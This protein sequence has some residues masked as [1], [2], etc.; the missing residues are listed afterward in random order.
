[1]TPPRPDDEAIA[2]RLRR[3]AGAPDRA[4]WGDVVERATSTARSSQGGRR[5]PRALRPALAV[6]AVAGLAGIVG[7]L[8]VL[9]PKDSP[10]ARTAWTYQTHVP[11][12]EASIPPTIR[13][14]LAKLGPTTLPEAVVPLLSGATFS[15]AV[16]AFRGIGPD[17]RYATFVLDVDRNLQTRHISDCLAD[18]AVV[19]RDPP[20][21]P[22]RIVVPDVSGLTPDEAGSLLQ[23]AGLAVRRLE[24]PAPGRA[25]G[26]A[27]TVIPPIGTSLYVGTAV[28]VPSV[29]RLGASPDA[30]SSPVQL[31]DVGG[32]TR[33]RWI[34]GTSSPDVAGIATAWPDAITVDGRVMN[35]MFLLPLLPRDCRNVGPP[36]S[37]ILTY[38]GG[39][40]IDRLS[41]KNELFVKLAD[42]WALDPE[43]QCGISVAPPTYSVFDRPITA[44]DVLPPGIAEKPEESFPL[45]ID[46]STV[47][48]AR[49]T[50]PAGRYG[51]LTLI[52]VQPAGRRGICMYIRGE[53]VGSGGTCRTPSRPTEGEFVA[54][55]RH[56]A[57]DDPLVVAGV[58]PD[59]FTEVRAGS[60]TSTVDGNVWVLV[61][62]ANDPVPPQVTAVRADGTSTP[63]TI[64]TS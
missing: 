12:D 37:L 1:M 52:V 6:A 7:V 26:I 58:L 44:Q 59:G 11:L 30:P 53:T 56:S 60:R 32:D 62:A 51:R 40:K 10:P 57:A 34:M 9:A 36:K 24:P 54:T 49:T 14:A 61:Y 35:G 18:G 42:T 64:P 15:G 25:V 13:A 33:G 4:D 50:K 27:D 43:P 38:A 23:Q 48:V 22:R 17:G 28:D 55:M 2:A 20:S 16:F 8:L 3:L 5:W 47:R 21:A 46:T 31:C 45:P 19:P 29:S 41:G 39:P 63:L